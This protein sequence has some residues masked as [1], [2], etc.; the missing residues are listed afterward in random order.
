MAEVQITCLPDEWG[1]R[2]WAGH[3][4]A[5]KQKA[6]F[7]KSTARIVGFLF[8]LLQVLLGIPWFKTS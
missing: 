7:T 1:Q 4:C 2:A 8:K 5:N 3:L 6:P